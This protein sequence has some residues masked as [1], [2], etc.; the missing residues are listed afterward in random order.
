[1]AVDDITASSTQHFIVART[2]TTFESHHIK[3]LRF[4]NGNSYQGADLKAVCDQ[5]GL[6]QLVD[7]P[8][9]Q[10]YLLDLF[11]TDMSRA[12]VNVGPC[13]AD[14]KMLVAQIPLPII[15]S[16]SITRRSFKLAKA[17]WRGL[18]DALTQVDCTPLK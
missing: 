13:I 12:K 8:T 18:E 16:M 10:E 5:F 15:S 17:N 11:L 6:Q 3:W 9:R 14:H 4:S 2:D 7:E 1:M